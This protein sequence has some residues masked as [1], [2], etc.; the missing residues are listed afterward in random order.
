MFNSRSDI[1]KDRFGDPEEKK[2][3]TQK[4]TGH[5]WNIKRPNKCIITGISESMGRKKAELRISKMIK[6][7]TPIYSK[8]SEDPKQD[9]HKK[10]MVGVLIIFYQSFKD[11]VKISQAIRLKAH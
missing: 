2:G 1:G 7:I 11:K 6:D 9:K 5:K 4:S 10:T 3:C 8:G